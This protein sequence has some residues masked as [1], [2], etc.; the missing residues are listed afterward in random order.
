MMWSDLKEGDRIDARIS[1]AMARSMPPQAVAYM[2]RLLSEEMSEEYDF[3]SEESVM[4]AAPAGPGMPPGPGRPPRPDLPPGP[5]M[6]PGQGRPPRP[7]VEEVTIGRIWNIDRNNRRFDTITGQDFSSL[8]RF[9]VPENTRILNRQGRTM[10][11]SGLM[12]GMRVQVRHANFMTPS[13]PPQTTAFEVRV[14]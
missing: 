4:T 8:T 6:P 5:G 9:N 13:I 11:F 10:N 12:I 2:I 1:D 3:Q 14:L 7:P